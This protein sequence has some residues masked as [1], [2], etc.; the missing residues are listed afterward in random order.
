MEA[1]GLVGV[2]ISEPFNQPARG[3][4]RRRIGSINRVQAIVERDGI[5]HLKFDKHACR[6]IVPDHGKRHHAPTQAGAEQH[7][8][9]A[10]FR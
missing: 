4:S 1:F 6:D 10:Q 5:R 8:L 9:R 7:V 2:L 3:R